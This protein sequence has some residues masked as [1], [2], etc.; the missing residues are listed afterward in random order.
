M[1]RALGD[2]VGAV[3]AMVFL[4]QALLA[5]GEVARAEAVL[6]DALAAIHDIDY[7]QIL[8]AAMRAVAQLATRRGDDIAAARW[9][10]AADGVM[11]ALG[12]E[13]SAARRAG[14]DRAVAAM[15]ERLGEAAF[16]TAWGEGR[17][18]PAG[19]V[20]FT[21]DAWKADA[22][23]SDGPDAG[24]R[25][26]ISGFTSRQRD[27][28]RLMAWGGPTRRSPAH[29]TSLAPLLPS[30]SQGSW[31]SSRS[32]RA[33]R[34]SPSPSATGSSD[35]PR[36]ASLCAGNTSHECP[37]SGIHP[38]NSALKM[39]NPQTIHTGSTLAQ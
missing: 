6:I 30:T 5:E 33:P 15:R 31:Q 27:V 32:T 36:L 9:Y 24:D 2:R 12:M 8:P 3:R 25:G 13:L 4:G 16:A 7:K 35:V 29:C 26:G 10:G 34:R 22:D 18:G 37:V 38:P 14:H 21:F 39:G 1:W 28:L 20:A 19:L 11:E 23:A 17:A